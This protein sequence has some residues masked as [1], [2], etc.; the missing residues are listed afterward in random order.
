MVIGQSGE[1]PAEQRSY[2]GAEYD[3]NDSGEQSAEEHS[4]PVYFA[5]AVEFYTRAGN[6]ACPIRTFVRLGF[7]NMT[8]RLKR[9]RGG[10]MRECCKRLSACRSLTA[11]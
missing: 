8:P 9:G 7:E 6:D 2:H 4:G 10:Q 11:T 5:H 3:P 1:I